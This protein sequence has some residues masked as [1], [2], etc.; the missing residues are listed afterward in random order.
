MIVKPIP[1]YMFY[2]L[3]KKAGTPFKS[4]N[5]RSFIYGH[6]NNDKIAKVNDADLDKTVSKSLRIYSHML[7]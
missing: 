5:T 2:I 3:E 1:L 4:L 6:I 7:R